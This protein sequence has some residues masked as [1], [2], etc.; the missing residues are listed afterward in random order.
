MSQRKIIIKAMFRLKC[1]MNKS[2]NKNFQLLKM[3]HQFK[4][5][6][7]YRIKFIKNKNIKKIL[8]I[9]KKVKIVTF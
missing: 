3:F 5:L 4:I 6:I 8:N 7:A 9:L 1:K 2:K